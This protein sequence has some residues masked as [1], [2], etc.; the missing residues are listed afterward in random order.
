MKK[1]VKLN[2]FS[3]FF[4]QIGLDLGSDR[5]RIWQAGNGI[6]ADEPARI[7]VDRLSG[8]VLAVGQDA[9]DMEGRVAD[10][11]AVV[12][13]MRD[14]ELYDARAAQT[15]LK[16][17]LQ[18]VY[19]SRLVVN[20]VIL[21]SVPAGSTQ[22]AREAMTQL[23][24]SL[25]AREAYTI[26]APLAASIGAGV[27][28]ADASGSF[29]LHL[30]AGVVEGAVISLGS[31]VSHE[32]TRY[33]GDYLTDRVRYQ[34]KKT[35]TLT[36]SRTTA[37]L[38]KRNIASAHYQASREQLVAGQDLQTGNPKEVMI[39]AA[40]LHPEITQIIK[41]Y[42]DLLRQLLSNIP[43][44]LTVD[45]IDKGLLLSGGLA[46][47]HGLEQHLTKTLGIATSVVEEPDLAVINGIGTVLE[48]LDQFTESLAY[49]G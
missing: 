9:L 18:K 39:T 21:G 26:A 41:R 5:V 32:T 43:P 35:Q 14:G 24:Y 16:V 8:R 11:I 45:V 47:I 3:Q 31:L 30:G 34:I 15:F 40:T 27:P 33:A 10:H 37:E 19:P 48:H 1:V 7:A 29:F 4:Q 38:V 6:V 25:G 49:Q 22:A 46:Q 36:V 2:F 42:E 23:L 20:P 12:R 44:E 28:I 17:L 13:P